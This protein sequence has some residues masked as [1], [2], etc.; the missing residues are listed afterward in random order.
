MSNTKVEILKKQGL[1]PLVVGLPAAAAMLSLSENAAR[2]LF[3]AYKVP[4]LKLG[5]RRVIRVSDI[6]HLIELLASQGKPP[7]ATGR[8]K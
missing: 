3:D 4:V 5:A 7:H 6:E 8:V 1:S 2:P